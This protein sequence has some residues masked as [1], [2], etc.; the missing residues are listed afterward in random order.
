MN[1]FYKLALVVPSRGRPENI[2]R[3]WTA[4]RDTSNTRCT[5]L[6]VVVDNDDPKLLAYV[7]LSARYQT[8]ELIIQGTQNRLGPI[9]NQHAVYI[10]DGRNGQRPTH[11]GFMGDDHLPKT[12]LWDEKLVWSLKGRPGVAYGND[13]FQGANLPTAAVLSADIVRHLRYISPPPL[14]HLFIDNFWKQLGTDLDNLQ[15]REDVIIEHLHPVAGKA[16]VDAGYAFTLSS[17][18]MDL[19]RTSYHKFIRE[20]W[21]H[22][23][24][25]LKAC[26]SI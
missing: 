9:L 19:D 11:L 7:D 25:A 14:L 4:I 2:E 23:L 18:L 15:Y 10:A 16:A 3:L 21:P 12:S 8:F 20:T 26:L 24:Q 13:L 1:A 5:E 22:Q 6:H 17:S